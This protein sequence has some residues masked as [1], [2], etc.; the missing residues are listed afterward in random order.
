MTDAETEAR[1]KLVE[2]GCKALLGLFGFAAVVY[3]FFFLLI[4]Q[5]ASPGVWLFSAVVEACGFSGV[6]YWYLWHTSG[7]LRLLARI[8]SGRRRLTGV[9]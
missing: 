5:M 2:A 8:W 7:G 9:R 6:L 4:P 1:G 3:V